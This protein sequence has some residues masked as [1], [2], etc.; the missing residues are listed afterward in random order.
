M[1]SNI[2]D[3]PAVVLGSSSSSAISEMS[4]VEGWVMSSSLETPQMG[5]LMLERNPVTNDIAVPF[6]LNIPNGKD[7]ITVDPDE[8]KK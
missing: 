6:V 2:T 3:I 4:G 1:N 8:T 7:G 5:H